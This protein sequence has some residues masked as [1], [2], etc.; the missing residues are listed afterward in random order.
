[1]LVLLLML[2]TM[3]MLAGQAALSA[4]SSSNHNYANN[5]ALSRQPSN[6]DI[7]MISKTSAQE[8]GRGYLTAVRPERRRQVRKELAGATPLALQ[9]LSS[10]LSQRGAPTGPGRPAGRSLNITNSR[11]H[12]PC[13]PLRADNFS[14]HC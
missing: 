10:C 13:W 3:S 9:L 6:S 8:A 5:Q 4:C 12:F 7:C 2:M 1:M 14:H 11:M